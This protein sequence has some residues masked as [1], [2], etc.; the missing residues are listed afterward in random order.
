[1][2]QDLKCDILIVG[3][4]CG[5][6]AAALSACSMGLS[7]VLSEE[8]D[9]I[10]GQLTSQLVPPDE[11]RWIEQFGA[12]KRYRDFRNRIRRLYQ[13][14]LPLT[15]AAKSNPTLNPG[16]GWVSRICFEPRIGW[17]ALLTML[18]PYMSC[19]RLKILKRT[20]PI[21]AE[22]HG[23]FLCSV[24]FRHKE[25]QNI[26]LVEAKFVLDATELGDILELAQVE[27]VTGAEAQSETGEEHAEVGEAHPARMQGI[28]W[29][30]ILAHDEGSHRTIDRPA[31]YSRWKD[32]QPANWPT[33][34]FDFEII[35]PITGAKR[36]LPLF[37][38]TEDDWANLFSYRQIRD[39]KIF[40]SSPVPHPATVVN[41]PQND[42]YLKPII[43]VAEFEKALTLDE[44]KSQTLNLLYWL[45]TDAPRHD[46]GTG[47]PGL[48][49]CPELAGTEDGLAQAPYIRE[50]RRIR[51][52]FTITE[53]MV[54]V[55]A[56]PSQD[57]ARPMPKPVGVG[58]YRMDLH[59]CTDLGP[60]ID[61]GALP[62]QIPLGALL[63]VRMKNLIA[64][65]KNIGTTHIT[66]GCY[67]LHPTEWNIGE[68]AGLLAAFCCLKSCQPHEVLQSDSVFDE[69]CELLHQQGV[70][71]EW[72]ADLSS[73]G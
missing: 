25:T 17:I 9:W 57:R 5:G 68:S 15:D 27:S 61:L 6:V 72:P 40:D 69:F 7:V 44:A 63:P 34:L 71:T 22:T 38:K 10:G 45:Q 43:G 18:Q 42:Y 58:L 23:D 32:L 66:N 33:K 56:N 16:S 35:N 39:P 4:G 1:M 70:E 62:Y 13:S 46:G 21:A 67:R 8:Y 24:T 28:T 29:C 65:A 53:P 50:S 41:W 14:E 37:G 52:L 20:I 2:S 12:T 19:G 31:D 48:Y 11:H 51:S 54:S 3:G 36:V 30:A 64:A 49:L 73:T 26:V 47:Y 55:E 59:P 60:T